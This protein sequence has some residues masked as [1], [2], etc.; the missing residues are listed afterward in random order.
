[1]RSK[2]WL[3]VVAVALGGVAAFAT[4]TYLGAL[5]RQ[6]ES[7]STMTDVLV[8]SRDIP[9]GVSGNDLMSAGSVSP[10]KMPLRYV[11]SGA[12]SSMRGV[13]DRILA[14]PVA[15]GEVLTTARFQ[16]PSEAGLAFSVPKG[17][18]AVT[19]PVDDARGV[20]G[21]V[22]PGDRVAVV[23]TVG[24]KSGSGDQ[25]RIVIPGVRVLAVGKSVGTEEV[26]AA[27]QGGG[28]GSGEAKSESARTVTLAVTA[29]DAEKV[30]FAAESG[31]L[32]LALL[33]TTESDAEPTNGQ[34]AGTVLK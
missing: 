18:L 33:A 8:A 5:Q 24:T 21:L 25:T 32:W 27:K 20:A 29:A 22:K 13:L 30:V 16:Y 23:I 2:L 17:L 6:A 14:V 11:S 26:A 3:V 4:F 31:R 34:S 7:G 9:R 12:I 1:M 19:V 28:I 10:D 15:K